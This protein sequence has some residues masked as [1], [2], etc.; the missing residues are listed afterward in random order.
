[1]LDEAKAE[2]KAQ[3]AKYMLRKMTGPREAKYRALMKFQRAKGI[4]DTLKWTIGVR[5]QASPMD[6]GLG[7]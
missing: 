1:L 5:G 7:D 2:M 4:V 3:H 6:E